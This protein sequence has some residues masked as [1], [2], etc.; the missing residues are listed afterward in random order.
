MHLHINFNFGNEK[1]RRQKNNILDAYIPLWAW[2]RHLF[3]A[4]IIARFYFC[5]DIK[6]LIQKKMCSFTYWPLLLYEVT[7][8]FR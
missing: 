7:T 8:N 1:E 3:Q 6:I 4:E 2:K 5:L